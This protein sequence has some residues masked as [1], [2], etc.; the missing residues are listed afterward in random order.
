MKRAIYRD[1]APISRKKTKAWRIGG[2]PLLAP[3]GDYGGPTQTMPPLP[4]SPAIDAGDNAAA[5]GLAT[6]QRGMARVQSGGYGLPVVDIGAVEWN[7][8]LVG[9]DVSS[10][11]PA[12]LLDGSVYDSSTVFPGGFDPASVGMI[13]LLSQSEQN[14]LVSEGVSQ[15]EAN[16]TGNPEIY[17]LYTESAFR[18]L[19]LD[20]P[21]LVYNAPSQSFVLTIGILETPDLV[22]TPFTNLT[23]FTTTSYPGDGEIDVEFT[24]PNSDA[25]FYE[26]YGS[27]PPPSP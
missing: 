20:R 18:A 1:P 12:Y 2:D 24:P 15:G 25:R 21:F 16:V 3:L 22:S 5:S 6:D 11:D 8:W 27:E 4:G 10:L 19:A 9:Q 7:G 26:V 13:A 17:D 14:N 23:G